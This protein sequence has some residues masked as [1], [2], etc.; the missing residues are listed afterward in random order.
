MRL[1]ATQLHLCTNAAE[2]QQMY[3]FTADLAWLDS[4]DA[5]VHHVSGSL[6][7]LVQARTPGS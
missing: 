1:H 6:C 5:A 7:L 2:S 3:Y 4:P